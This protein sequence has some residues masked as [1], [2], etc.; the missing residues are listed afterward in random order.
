[1][2]AT[3]SEKQTNGKSLM[4][5]TLK[6]THNTQQ[7]IAHTKALS[8]TSTVISKSLNLQKLCQ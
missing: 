6:T 3:A 7:W 8:Q 4:A 5:I 1:M 2:H